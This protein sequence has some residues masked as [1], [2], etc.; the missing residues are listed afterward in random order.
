MNQSIYIP[1]GIT[2]KD[3]KIRKSIIIDFYMKFLNG[4]KERLVYNNH[5]E[6]YIIVN[7]DSMYETANWASFRYKST[8]AVLQLESVLVLAKPIGNPVPTKTNTKNQKNFEKMLIMEYELPAIG[9]VKL[10]VGILKNKKGNQQYSL[11]A[12]EK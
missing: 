11:T 10:L 12:I 6:N 4:K 9:K 7:K 1:T 5:L 8:L 2:S 3:R